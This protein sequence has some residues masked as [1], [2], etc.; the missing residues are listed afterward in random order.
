MNAI[1]R[2]KIYATQRTRL[3]EVIPLEVP[4]S[5]QIDI[6]SACNMHCEFCVHSDQ[7]A[8]K[9]A[10]I[11]WG[12]MPL[13]LYK[14]IIDDIKVSWGGQTKIKKL[15][16][17]QIGE[18]LLHPHVCEMIAYAKKANVADYIEITTNATLLNQN[19][20]LELVDAGLDILNI[21]LN[22][23]NEKQYRDACNYELSFEEFR[24][25][26]A[27]FYQ[28]RKQC[29]MFIKYSDM[30]YSE[31]MKNQ[32]YNLFGNICDEIFVET[33]SATLWQDTDVG[34]KFQNAHVG[35]YGQ[36][37]IEKKV[38]PFLFTTLIISDQGLAHLC[39]VDWKLKHIL[40]DLNKESISDV[41]NGKRLKEYQ[42]LHLRGDKNKIDIC[43]DCE[44]LSANNI[45]NIDDYADELLKRFEI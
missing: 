37:I 39:C 24:N 31:E 34:N 1:K 15:R 30:G 38:C 16:L 43:K 29:R 7:K 4:F 8:V 44:S 33:I 17:F 40:G 6:C 11:R 35:T 13:E 2:G 12:M 45:D 22:G 3:E 28:N 36:E 27:H 5:V 19:L 18:P 26:I 20:N 41:W 32:F 25:N 10:G 23:I 21:S 9:E 42:L 14:H